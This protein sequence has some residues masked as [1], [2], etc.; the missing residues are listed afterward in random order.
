MQYLSLPK[1]FYKFHSKEEL[2]SYLQYTR[3]GLVRAVDNSGSPWQPFERVLRPD[4][5]RSEHVVCSWCMT[6]F[7]CSMEEE[8]TLLAAHRKHCDYNR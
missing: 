6:L 5:Q 4:G 1:N 2:D 8:A 7:T 3:C